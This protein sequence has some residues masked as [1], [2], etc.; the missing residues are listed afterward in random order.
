[1]QTYRTRAGAV[2]WAGRLEVNVNGEWGTV[3]DSDFDMKEA[4]IV[5]RAMGYGS[6]KSFQVRASYG[7]GVGKIHYSNL[8]LVHYLQ[9]VVSCDQSIEVM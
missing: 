2:P 5:C 4:N 7:K 9:C 6:A 3:C 1:M 8:R